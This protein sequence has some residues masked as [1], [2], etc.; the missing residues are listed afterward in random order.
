MRCSSVAASAVTAAKRDWI[1]GFGKGAAR[2]GGRAPVAAPRTMTPD[3]IENSDI[4]LIPLAKGI[5]KE[6]HK[7]VKKK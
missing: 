2:K 6:I 4:F 5:V 1:D 3:E 7:D